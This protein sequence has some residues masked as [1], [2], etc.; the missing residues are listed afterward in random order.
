MT[1]QETSDPAEEGP[2]NSQLAV[3]GHDFLMGAKVNHLVVEARPLDL[4]TI[5]GSHPASF[6]FEF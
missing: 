1:G 4:S 6:L 5:W 2:R 3:A